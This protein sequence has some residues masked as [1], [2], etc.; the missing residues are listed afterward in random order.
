[1]IVPFHWRASTCA[2]NYGYYL[3]FFLFRN[4]KWK[5]YNIVCCRCRCRYR[6]RCWLYA[7]RSTLIRAVLFIFSFTHIYISCFS[8]RLVAELRAI[9]WHLPPFVTL[10]FTH[11]PQIK[12]HRGSYSARFV[13]QK[14]QWNRGE[15]RCTTFFRFFF[16]VSSLH[17]L[18]QCSVKWCENWQLRR[19][20]FPIFSLSSSFWFFGRNQ[21][22]NTRKS[23][24]YSHIIPPRQQQQIYWAIENDDIFFRMFSNDFVVFFLFIKN[25]CAFR[26]PRKPFLFCSFDFGSLI[27]LII[28]C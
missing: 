21:N 3:F 22:A 20:P 13:H 11:R 18:F 16:C 19:H 28:W 5:I 17:L 23:L 4:E 10:Y 1:M 7:L 8:F 15:K 24:P 26:I 14:W 12:T 27:Y 25:E 6:C 9:G 2:Q